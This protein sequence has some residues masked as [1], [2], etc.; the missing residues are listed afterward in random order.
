MLSNGERI[1]TRT[2]IVTAGISPN[3]LIASL[4][5]E[6]AQGRVVCDDYCRVK[7]WSGVYAA[8]DSAAVRKPTTKQQCPPTFLYAMSQGMCAADNML[9]EL[10]HE[11]PRRYA[12]Q[13]IGELA[14]LS[15]GYAVATLKGVPLHGVVASLIGRCF[16]L[17]YI[18]TW[19]RRIGLLVDWLSA[20]VFA[21]DITQIETSR[22]D[23][24]VPMRF[25]PGDV[26][27]REGEPGSRFYI[28]AEGTVE[29]VRQLATGEEQ[30]LDVLGPGQYFGEMALLHAGKRMASVRAVTH[31]RVLSIARD[32]FS[33]LVSHLAVLRDAVEEKVR[34]S[35]RNLAAIQP[36]AQQPNAEHKSVD[37][38]PAVPDKQ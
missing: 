13:A 7:N 31:T 5:V 6:L 3:P 25:D 8:G 23:T 38:R 4:P 22:S 19:R 28:I 15:N 24:I 21:S 33:T 37:Q 30:Q 11:P 17:A 36:S 10:R 27:V 18:P 16:F 9:R 1:P 29:V 35:Q 32:E 14:F 20:S 2:V 26:I 34:L 12:Y